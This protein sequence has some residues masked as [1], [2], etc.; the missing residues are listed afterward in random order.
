M[1]TTDLTLDEMRILKDC[2]VYD[3]I[4]DALVGD[5]SRYYGGSSTCYYYNPAGIWLDPQGLVQYSEH[6]TDA[7]F[8]PWRKIVDFA[9]GMP[10]KQAALLELRS[11]ARDLDGGLP[12]YEPGMTPAERAVLDCEWDR[13]SLQLAANREERRNLIGSMF[14]VVELQGALF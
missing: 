13:V 1:A 14:E 10:S 5:T 7:T 4:E 2:K 3:T 9:Q 6:R 12:S 8:I 11:R